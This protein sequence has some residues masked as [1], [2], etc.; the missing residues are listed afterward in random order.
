MQSVTNRRT[1]VR[2]VVVGVPMM[3]GVASMSHALGAYPLHDGA[4][5]EPA[6]DSML[7]D[8]ARLHNQMRRRPVTPDD[9]RACA[10]H[11][12]S[13]AAYQAHSRDAAFTTS[14]R[15]AIERLGPLAIVSPPPDPAGMRHELVAFGFDSPMVNGSRLSDV[16]ARV[17]MLHRIARSGL[18][19]LFSESGA[20]MA[21]YELIYLTT[22]SNTCETLQAMHDQMEVLAATM[23]AIA[24]ALPVVAPECFAAT[25]VLAALKLMIWAGGC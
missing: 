25:C 3:A 23:C 11:M 5:L 13:L 10:A 2:N 22:V 16:D 24:V 1:F 9:V 12:R 6:L 7:R 21:D 4:R 8:L 15:D 19:P 14:V 17:E 20:T 18:A